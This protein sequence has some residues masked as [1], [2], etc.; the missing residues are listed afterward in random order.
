MGE[1]AP[2]E[3]NQQILKDALSAGCYMTFGNTAAGSGCK[4]DIWG[5]EFWGTSFP[6]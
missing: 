3:K 6:H 1:A 2:D 4:E 5:E